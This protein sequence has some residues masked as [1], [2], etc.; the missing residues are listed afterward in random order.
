[1]VFGNN[2]YGISYSALRFGISALRFGISL[3]II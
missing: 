3:F 2:E 1:M